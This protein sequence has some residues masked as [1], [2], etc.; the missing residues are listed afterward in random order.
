MKDNSTEVV[1]IINFICAIFRQRL[2]SYVLHN[3]TLI[4]W[5]FITENRNKYFSFLIV[6]Q[7]A[8]IS[9]CF[10][11]RKCYNLTNERMSEIYAYIHATILD[12]IS[13]NYLK[14]LLVSIK[15]EI[16]K[17]YM[18]TRCN[19]NIYIGLKI[20]LHFNMWLSLWQEYINHRY[21]FIK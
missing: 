17:S 15:S 5:N 16:V 14:S 7:Y 4:T 12:K 11:I 13:L 3:H 18:V 21:S 19:P 8:L 1:R 6:R 20:A 2:W 9:N 10:Y